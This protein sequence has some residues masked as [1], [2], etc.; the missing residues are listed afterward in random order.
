MRP[1]V[2]EISRLPWRRLAALSVGGK[3]RNKRLLEKLGDWNLS[4]AGRH[5]ILSALN[6]SEAHLDL[7]IRLAGLSDGWRPC[8]SSSESIDDGLEK[9]AGLGLLFLAWPGRKIRLSDA[10]RFLLSLTASDSFGEAGRKGNLSRPDRY[11]KTIEDY[12]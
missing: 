11:Q 10:G 12:Q 7:L 6:L 5:E 4:L 1:E 2:I 3:K 8:R 9:L